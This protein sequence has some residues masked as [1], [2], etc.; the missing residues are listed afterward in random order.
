MKVL[1]IDDDPL[2]RY[3][4][5]K[6]LTNHGYDVATAT[7]GEQGFD[8]LANEAPA[9]VITDLIMPGQEGIETIG[10]LKRE[11]P[12]IRIIAISGGGR[13]CNLNMLPAAQLMGADAIVAKPFEADE[14]LT[15][16][17]RLCNSLPHPEPAA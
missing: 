15:P 10:R 11:R 8:Y 16:L 9:V 6:L 5:S 13:F 17:R 7:D 4:L 12:E 1:V 3:A 2:V 14:L